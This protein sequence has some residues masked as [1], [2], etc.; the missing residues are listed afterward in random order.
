MARRR[1]LAGLCGIVLGMIIFAGCGVS[2]STTPAAT[3]SRA[4]SQPSPTLTPLPTLKLHWQARN[5]PNTQIAF[6]PDDANTFYTCAHADGAL[7]AQ[8]ITSHDG[9]AHMSSVTVP[10]TN[11]G[12]SC[13][14]VADDADPNIAILKITQ[15]GHGPRP[16]LPPVS[17]QSSPG[18]GNE[19]FDLFTLDGGRSWQTIPHD[20][21]IDEAATVRN[22]TYAMI[23]TVQNSSPYFAV[24]HD[25]FASWQRL[26]VP[27]AALAM[28]TDYQQNRQ[29]TSPSASNTGVG[30]LQQIWVNPD[31]RHLLFAPFI[32]NSIAFALIAS[33]D[34]GQSWQSLPTPLT[35]A[36]FVV[37][38]P[39]IGHPWSLCASDASTAFTC[40]SDGGHLWTTPPSLP[41]PN[42]LIGIT[43]HGDLLAITSPDAAHTVLER[44]NTSSQQWQSLGNAPNFPL[45]LCNMP[46]SDVLWGRGNGTSAFP[47]YGWYEASYTSQ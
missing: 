16:V 28:H 4:T 15:D 6:A 17:S 1:D 21:I 20:V 30:H 25:G 23:G 37:Q 8:A 2:N 47:V 18:P 13:T 40:T 31:G 36:N 42:S 19:V 45:T 39:I 38:A 9:G 12:G 3:S 10:A 5:L 7:T 34:G 27:S 43:T 14:P 35:I 41:V 26:K 29:T 22:M 44:Y 33:S 24:S 11:H 32:A 46:S